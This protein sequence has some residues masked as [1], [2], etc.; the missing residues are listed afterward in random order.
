MQQVGAKLDQVYTA[1]EVG[2]SAESGKNPAAGNVYSARDGKMYKFVLYDEGTGALDLAAGDVVYYV[3]DTG[4]GAHTVTAD[5]SDATGQELGA[6]VVVAT[7]VD[8]DG[9]YFWIQIKGAATVNQ[10]IGGT[11][12]DGDPLTC[13][14]ASDKALTKAAES[15]TAAVYKPVVAYAVDASAKEIICDFPL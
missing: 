15:D 14:G 2:L 8:T 10:T 12:A 1:S 11:P 6:G 7:T 9:S 4:Y 13:V 3:D 5:V